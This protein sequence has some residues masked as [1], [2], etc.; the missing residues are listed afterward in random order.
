MEKF[1]ALDLVTAHCRVMP[2][3]EK[4]FFLL[5]G[6]P[7][8][9]KSGTTSTRSRCP[10]RCSC[11]LSVQ[12]R[13]LRN[14]ASHERRWKKRRTWPLNHKKTRFRAAE[15]LVYADFLPPES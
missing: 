10:P 9:R 2:F 5:N 15:A 11:A 12:S 14:A 1:S 13:A 3:A 7:T 6:I 4:R 8:R